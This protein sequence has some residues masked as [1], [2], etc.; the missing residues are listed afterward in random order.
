MKRNFFTLVSFGFLAIVLLF[1]SYVLA[2]S[3][4]VF[5]TA[6][7]SS[8]SGVPPYLSNTGTSYSQSQFGTLNSLTNSS[9][10]SSSGNSSSASGLS[11]CESL[12][13]SGLKGVGQCALGIINAIIPIII[14]GTV[15]WVIWGSFNLV[16]SEEKEDRKKYGNVILYGVIALFVMVSVYGLVNILAGTFTGL[17][18]GSVAAPNVTS[19]ITQTQ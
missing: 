2:Q 12:T 6:T 19:S 3:P 15:V 17:Q 5:P 8:G 7:Q 14:A 11:A 9:G 18:G 16:K 4:N 1:P 13:T 10:L